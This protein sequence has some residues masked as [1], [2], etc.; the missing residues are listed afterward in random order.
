[1]GISTRSRFFNF[2]AVASIFVLAL[3]VTPAVADDDQPE[4]AKKNAA[5]V[6]NTAPDDVVVSD[7]GDPLELGETETIVVVG[8]RGSIQASTNKKRYNSS[9][10]EAISAEDIGK[11]PDSSIAESIA[12]LPGLAAQRLDGRANVISIRGLAPDFTTTTLNG[13]EQVSASNNRAVEYDQF[14][15]ELIHGVTIYKTPDASVTSQ[16]VGGTLDLQTVSPLQYGKQ[17]LTANIRSEYNDL[18][19][20]NAGSTALGYRG[21]ISYIDQFE[22]DTI[23]LAVGYARMSSPTQEERWNTWGYPDAADGNL[24]IGGAKPYVKSNEL[25]RDGLMAVLELKPNNENFSTTFDA[26]Y[27]KF[28]D[29]QLLRG[30]EIP[31]AWSAA[32][33]QP[34]YTLEDGLVVEGQYNDV[35]AVVRNDVVQRDADTLAIGWNTKYK[36]D[37]NK[38]EV[39]L[40]VSYSRVDRTESNLET[41]SGTGRG[42]GNGAVDDLGF[43]MGENGTGATF[44]HGLDYSNP[45]LIRLG[46]PLSWGY[47]LYVNGEYPD[48]TAQDGFINRPRTEDSLGAVKLSAKQRVN[49]PGFESVEYGL[50]LSRRQKSLDDEG[51]FL[52]L[53]QYPE[54][55]R[56]PGQFMLEPTS[57]AFIGMGNVL[58]YDA[59]ALY[60]SGAYSE[61][62]ESNSAIGRS[63]NSWDVTEN[64]FNTYAM[65]NI[66]SK[67]SNIDISGN[68]GVQVVYTDQSSRGFLASLQ[69]D[70]MPNGD[71]LQAIVRTRTKAGD[72][73]LDFLPSM[74]MTLG[75]TENQ[76]LRI[77]AA[78]ILARPRMDQMHAS[79]SVNYDSSLA[80][81]TD[82]N[83]SPWS[84][85]GGNPKL[86][87]WMTW[88]F[89]TSYEAYFGNG[90]YAAVAGYYKHISSFPFDQSVVRDFSDYLSLVS[91]APPTLT[92][93][94]ITAPENSGNGRIYGV[95][96]STSLPFGVFH[97]ALTGFGALFSASFADS[98]VKDTPES[99]PIELPGFSKTVLNGTLYFERAGFQARTSVRYRSSFLGEISGLS[100]IREKKFIEAETIVDAQ[101][102][103]DLSKVGLKGLSAL[104]QAY[105]LTNQ[106]FTSFHGEDRRLVRD[107][108]NY[109]RTFLL[110]VT[111]KDIGGAI[112]P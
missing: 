36:S 42:S 31:L 101:L 110:G 81:S 66:H 61:V 13:R 5:Q 38:W 56:V 39:Q 75:I 23:G 69:E 35:E 34:G 87:P 80:N 60:N 96:L 32:A 12:R 95:E 63:V 24:I 90:G 88:Q 33:L 107:Y 17:T 78:R 93:G 49:I 94:L 74:N 98:S 9:I 53:Q 99:D 72:Q 111:W 3:T 18:G 58:S 91:D 89:D 76:K 103:Y 65:T 104:L 19:A 86:R 46:G 112:S 2:L 20:L 100:L 28:S 106:S 79:S 10:V 7:D 92:E 21:S 55:V 29:T 37:N 1:M 59:Q 68:A 8:I 105:N 41:Y 26:Y 73:F 82:I 97:H 22:D 84:G 57:L 47:G 64:V 45:D 50:R 109:G 25:I 77:G 11:L 40:D 67:I 14:P 83:N 52:T 16:A 15:S 62:L 108:Q 27:S 4:E 51:V 85:G 30:I 44:T 43:V 48:Q 102:A 71:P 70:T 6:D 54:D